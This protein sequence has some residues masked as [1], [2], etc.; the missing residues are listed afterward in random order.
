[1]R[2]LACC[3]LGRFHAAPWGGSTLGPG[4]QAPKSWLAPSQFAARPPNLAVLLTH[5]GQLIIRKISKFDATRCQILRLKCT[6]FDFRWGCTTE[7]AE[8]VYSAPPDSLAVFKGTYFYKEREREDREGKREEKGRERKGKGS[9][10]AKGEGKGEGVRPRTAPAWGNC[11]P[12]SAP[13]QSRRCLLHFLSLF[14]S[15]TNNK[16]VKL[17]EC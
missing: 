15:K 3:A 12:T 7:P 2:P 1:L 4:G 17:H 5:C 8:R 6:T 11:L 14:L 13:P 16:S 10:G 9:G